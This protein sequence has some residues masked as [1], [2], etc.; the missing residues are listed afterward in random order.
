[1]LHYYCLLLFKEWI[2]PHFKFDLFKGR[3][4]SPPMKTIY[5]RSKSPSK[6]AQNSKPIAFSIMPGMDACD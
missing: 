4:E 5:K 3:W 2:T 6:L 1:M